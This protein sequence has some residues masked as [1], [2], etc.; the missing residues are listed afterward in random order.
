V[1][2]VATQTIPTSIKEVGAALIDVS[3]RNLEAEVDV[4]AKNPDENKR[5]K[6]H[7]G[8]V[9]ASV[10]SGLE[11]AAAPTSFSKLSEVERRERLAVS[12]AEVA[13]VITPLRIEAEG[14][15]VRE[16]QQRAAASAVQ[17]Q[18]AALSSGRKI[19]LNPQGSGTLSEGVQ[20]N[21]SIRR[22]AKFFSPSPLREPPGLLSRLEKSGSDRAQGQTT[23]TIKELGYSYIEGKRSGLKAE[24]D[25][26][27]TDP[28]EH[29]KC[30]DMLTYLTKN[31][32]SSWGHSTNVG[33]L[34]RLSPDQLSQRAQEQVFLI[35][36]LIRPFMNDAHMQIAHKEQKKLHEK[37]LVVKLAALKRRSESR[38]LNK[39][40]L[41]HSMKNQ[42]ETEMSL[43]RGLAMGIETVCKPVAW[44]LSVSQ[45]DDQQDPY[46]RF[47]AEYQAL[48]NPAAEPTL[49]KEFTEA[50][51]AGFDFIPKFY[52]QRFD[53]PEEVGRQYQSDTITI[54]ATL[55]GFGLGKISLKGAAAPL[56]SRPGS[57]I[58]GSFRVV[59]EQRALCLS[60]SLVKLPH[61]SVSLSTQDVVL[62]NIAAN[63]LALSTS[64][65]RAF[66]LEIV[67][68]KAALARPMISG[69]KPAGESVVVVQSV[70][71]CNRALQVPIQ[72]KLQ[73]FAKGR[74]CV[75]K[76]V[77]SVQGVVDVL[78]HQGNVSHLLIRAHGNSYMIYLNAFGTR[79]E[80]L[81]HALTQG[82]F[83]AYKQ[84]QV[85]LEACCTAQKP[86]DGSLS[87]A[88]KLDVYSGDKLS[89]IAGKGRIIPR[90]SEMKPGSIQFYGPRAKDEPKGA[91]R[92]EVTVRLGR[93]DHSEN[94]N[95]LFK[96]GGIFS[97]SKFLQFAQLPKVF[98]GVVGKD[99][100]FVHYHL[101]PKPSY[102][103]FIS[104]S[105]VKALT[106]GQ[107]ACSLEPYTHMTVTKIPAGE[108]INTLRGQVMAEG[109]WDRSR[110]LGETTRYYFY[111]FN[112]KWQH[113]TL[114]RLSSFEGIESFDAVL[115][116][117]TKS[118]ERPVLSLRPKIL[119]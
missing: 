30:T 113:V 72:D 25:A 52:E 103:W 105:D 64:G 6:A 73:Q 100:F 77:S 20:F 1:S 45:R 92:P 76:E 14:Y 88:S 74:N 47:V 93:I 68:K 10:R 58:E 17:A 102:D 111:D 96:G 67:T 65:Y 82:C 117:A 5:I 19:S 107:G 54:A 69:M 61:T 115:N 51:R 83:T 75:F 79:P 39:D 55:A 33:F 114:D 89:I 18:V 84:A 99:L 112:P 57:F 23:S 94:Y 50:I 119:G 37:S 53:I 16:D 7:L 49:F 9:F 2:V 22:V 8:V 101:G 21:G 109:R 15:K 86:L 48:K 110:H 63:R 35:E 24:I 40:P 71:D 38:D 118:Q 32:R 12:C 34:D 116:R 44:I 87:F 78:Q 42:I 95:T 106:A 26:A 29:R 97:G 13:K 66:E 46:R 91:Y 98:S 60:A 31:A 56:T 90:F 27:I 41:Y 62:A 80:A 81:A 70:Y 11:L 59:E 3:Q 108:T 36:K 28:D 43:A 85:F 104:A 4:K